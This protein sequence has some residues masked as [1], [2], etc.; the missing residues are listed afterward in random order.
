MTNPF[1]L[2]DA[3]LAK[4]ESI[5]TNWQQPKAAPAPQHPSKYLTARELATYLKRPIGS[6]YQMQHKGIING[7]KMAGSSRLYYDID[8]IN[9]AL[10]NS[11]K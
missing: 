2:L 7:V 9:A 5:L 6:I 8:V 11:N 1:D 4:I 10:E 3:R